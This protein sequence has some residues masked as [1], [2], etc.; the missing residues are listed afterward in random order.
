MANNFVISKTVDS[1]ELQKFIKFKKYD[2]TGQ[3][4]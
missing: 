1:T 2:Q 4:F 3:S